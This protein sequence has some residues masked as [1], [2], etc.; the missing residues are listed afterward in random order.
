MKGAVEQL[1]AEATRALAETDCDECK[2]SLNRIISH[3]IGALTHVNQNRSY[4]EGR[5]E[6]GFANVAF[7]AKAREMRLNPKLRDLLG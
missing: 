2:T 1:K 4:P 7:T 5:L 6:T 3:C